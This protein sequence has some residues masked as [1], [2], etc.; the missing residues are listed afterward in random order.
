MHKSVD[1]ASIYQYKFQQDNP[2]E[3][4]LSKKDYISLKYLGSMLRQF[5]T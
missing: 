1:V 3:E 5:E 2:I 4:L